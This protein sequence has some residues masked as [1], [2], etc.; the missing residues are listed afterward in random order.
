MKAEDESPA[1]PLLPAAGADPLDTDEW[2]PVQRDLRRRDA[3]GLRLLL[4]RE[5]DLHCGPASSEEV[6]A[7]LRLWARFSQAVY[8]EQTDALS[9]ELG[10]PSR[11]PGEDIDWEAVV[12]ATFDRML[13]A[14][15]AADTDAG[16][17]GRATFAIFVHAQAVVFWEYSVVQ[18]E[19]AA[20]RRGLQRL[21]DS[22][23]SDDTVTSA[24]CREVVNVAARM[25]G[26]LEQQLSVEAAMTACAVEAIRVRA[27]DA[28]TM[29]GRARAQA[30]E[31]RRELARERESAN[32]AIATAVHLDA[33]LALVLDDLADTEAYNVLVAEAIAPASGAFLANLPAR[34]T[35][36]ATAGLLRA[37]AE[38]CR[39]FERSPTGAQSVFG[40]EVRAHRIPLEAAASALENGAETLLLPAADVTYLYPFGL[41]VAATGSD[42]L[43]ELMAALERADGAR[44]APVSALAG[45]RVSIDDAPRSDGWLASSAIQEQDYRAFRAVFPDHE[46]MLTTADGVTYAGLDLDVLLSGMGNHYIRVRLGTDTR[47]VDAPPGDRSQGWS[48]HELEQ[49][50]RRGGQFAGSEWVWL[51]TRT[52][53]VP[54]GAGFGS[55]LAL[56]TRVVADLAGAAHAQEGSPAGELAR[57]LAVV[58][59]FLARYCQ[60][61]VTVSRAEAVAPGDARRALVDEADLEG[62]LGVQTALTAQ[63]SLAQSALEW[64]AY[65]RAD[66]ELRARRTLG[67]RI[68][69]EVIWCA[70]DLTALFVPTAPHW[71]ALATRAHVEYASSLIGVYWRRQQWLRRVVDEVGAALDSDADQA[72]PEQLGVAAVRLGEA[73]RHVQLLVDRANEHT[74]SKDQQGREVLQHLMALNGVA[75]LRRTLDATIEAAQSTQTALADQL[76]KAR[77]DA[78]DEAQRRRQRPLEI[79]LAVLAVV[80]VIDVWGWVNAGWGLDGDVRWWLAETA[81]V[82]IVAAVLWWLGRRAWQLRRPTED[83]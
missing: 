11:A 29:L 14:F 33:L 58:E 32:L 21:A 50:I 80:G 65:P 77:A 8:D 9:Q 31:L 36:A 55:L 62:V 83:G 7:L 23:M 15:P 54:D 76:A 13:A 12:R 59:G 70:G 17:R 4:R 81:V 40:T 71:R 57:D 45:A 3:T 75:D 56:A 60:V 43:P 5:Y 79:L 10:L 34:E 67:G 6:G 26:C 1:R 19:V 73:I 28:A 37:A 46:L 27:A 69:R 48:P 74:L 82:A 18:E 53:G 63:R 78:E 16:A 22:A 49:A 20:L 30:Q 39:A 25:L 42:A 47:V 38:R 61:L 64:V 51:E 66:A 44:V 72:G 2:A 52:P 41:P 68:Q 24:R 35:D